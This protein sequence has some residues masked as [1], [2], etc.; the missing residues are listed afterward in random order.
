[1]KKIIK[2]L[3]I[4]IGIVILTIVVFFVGY[5]IKAKSEMRM[6]TPTETEKIVDNILSIKDSF[7][8]LYLI[9]DN[10]SYIAIDA[11][12][13]SEVVSDELKKL[14]IEP[15][16]VTAV[17]LTHTD[18]DHVASIKL[19]K[20]AIVYL[21]KQE[22]KLLNGEKSRFI[23]FGNK[24][25]AKEYSVI[26]D[27]QIF[28]IGNLK[29]KGILTPGHTVGSMCYLVND[30]YLFTGDLLSL[31][32]GKMAKFNEL[33]N[34]DTKTAIQSMKKITELPEAKY[35]FTAHYGYCDNYTNAVKDWGKLN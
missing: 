4:G 35:I 3:L 10:D 34:M 13:K 22:E 1:M 32:D 15:D 16:K 17:L 18:G 33:F 29:I 12:N 30:Q 31:K 5:G 9:K 7:V 26:D 24:I 2:R 14:N 19:F 21:S 27:Q 6:M 11:G 8:N 28:N 23:F 20:N 25:D